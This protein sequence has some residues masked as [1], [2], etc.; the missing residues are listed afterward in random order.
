[1]WVRIRSAPYL[2]LARDG[3]AQYVANALQSQL[4]V[5]THL[6]ALLNGAAAIAVITLASK[7]PAISSPIASRI[8]TVVCLAVILT[9][10]AV[11]LQVFRQK[12]HP[13]PFYL[14]FK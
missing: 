14:L 3:S 12:M 13:Y 6:V 5:E 11:E 9:V 10:L 7:A 4:G 8:A 1:M 2:A